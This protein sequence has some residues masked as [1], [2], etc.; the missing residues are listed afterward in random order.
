MKNIIW[1]NIG[2]AWANGDSLSDSI[3]LRRSL[4]LPKCCA[5]ALLTSI[6]CASVSLMSSAVYAQQSLAL[7]DSF[8]IGSG[9]DVLC[10][11]QS[12]SSNPILQSPFERSWAIVCRD[13]ARPVGYVFA[14]RET[15]G[16]INARTRQR[17]SENVDCSSVTAASEAQCT[18]RAGNIPYMV[19]YKQQGKVTYV[20]EGFA[21]YKDAIDLA[22]QSI[23]ADRIVPGEIR[24][25]TT[26]VGDTEAFARIQALTLAPDKA[27]AEGYRRNNSGDYA[28]ASAFFETLQQ[29]LSGEDKA[30]IDPNEFLINRALQ[31]SNLGDF[32]E[33]DALFEEA[34]VAPSKDP[35]QSRLTRNYEA[36]HLINQG[37]YQAAINRLSQPV[38][39]LQQ[40]ADALNQDAQITLPIAGRING[41]GRLGTLLNLV[42]DRKLSPQERAIII[43]AQA[44]QLSATAKRLNGEF[45]GAQTSLLE[46]LNQAVSVRDGR[47]VSI[48]RLRAQILAELGLVSEQLGRKQEAENY[49][50]AAI[51]IV[52]VQYPE[53]RALNATRARLAS[54]YIRNGEPEKARSIY[55]EIVSTSLSRRDPMTGFANQL[56]PYFSL[57]S[58]GNSNEV[59]A[60]E[61]FRATQILVRA[62]VA[63]TQAVLARE[64]SG[65]SEESSRLFRQSNN[66][67]RAIE[68][69]RIEFAAVNAM[70][71]R[72]AVISR[73]A[74][75]SASITELEADQQSTL[76]KLSAYPQYTVVSTRL[77]G[78][79]E[80]QSVMKPG[81]GFLRLAIA[82]N[83]VFVFFTDGNVQRAYKANITATEMERRV[84]VIR[85]S[86]SSY[87]AAAGAY[88]TTP[89]AVAEARSLYRDI[90]APVDGELRSLDHLVFEPDGAFLKLPI[91]LLVT[92]DASL[93]R[94]AERADAIDGDPFDVSD[95][96]WLAR[97]VAVS[98]AVS[99]RAFVDARNA[100]SSKA[101][102]QYLGLGQN[103]PVF[104]KSALSQLPRFRSEEA[105]RCVWPLAEWNKPIS[106]DELIKAQDIIGQNQSTLLIGAQFTDSDVK[107]RND[108]SDYR[109]LHFATHGLVSAPRPE[110]PA[111]PALL[112]SF[113]MDDSDGLLTFREIFDLQLD[114]DLVI[115]SACD[116]AGRATVSA[117]REAGLSTGGGGSLDGLVRAFV[118]AGGRSVMASHWPAPDDYQAT[119]RLITGVISEG[120]GR[121]I[122]SAMARAR[123][124]LMD[125]PLTSHP[126]YW[127]GFAIVG[128]G[129]RPV[130]PAELATATPIQA[131]STN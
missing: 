48:I 30:D 81:E 65:G 111:R 102:Q 27:L 108:L 72:P 22:Q 64:L 15:A 95:V 40:S 126:Y 112:T 113:G 23:I 89:F 131:A 34:Q 114:A 31:Q 92:D 53:T 75:L 86:I 1:S 119:N 96:Q 28:D 104:E 43:D 17:R 35:V 117:T 49:F 79:D 24:I 47:V 74:E 20:A 21:A 37:Q 50:Q 42:D 103:A 116:T 128:D 125:D 18:W 84:D 4:A 25:V 87:D 100:P 11:V 120:G 107:A 83:K 99:A 10:Q 73:R 66:I 51:D 78:L 94:F 19:S 45:E 71:D 98:T 54:F 90:F 16:D 68:R 38:E 123:T 7:K 26:S 91:D 32:A 70:E 57:L 46:A 88:I 101:S 110:C 62:G 58:D 82:S 41:D 39:A 76:L 93:D 118:G 67:N 106:G 124:P 29:R 2:L 6:L 36:I 130:R 44:K 105:N 5:K 77:L 55:R 56:E 13:S 63:E 121:S 80:L 52:A 61:F 97:D 115:L 127:A 60:A 14:L 129:A 59:D 69:L 109:I 12:E 33:A 3:Q 8:P 85:D 9:G 122:W